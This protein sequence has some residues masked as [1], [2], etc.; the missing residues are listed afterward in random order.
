M[1]K[2]HI[3]LIARGVLI[4]ESQLLV[5]E[6]VK[7]KYLFLPGGHVEFGESVEIALIR[8]MMEESGRPVS[9]GRFMGIFE[10]SF[11]QA[12]EGKA[13]KRHHE[14]NLIYEMTTEDDVPIA[15][16]ESKIAFRWIPIDDLKSKGQ[17]RPAGILEVALGGA[18]QA[19]SMSE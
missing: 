13:A 16:I 10:A 8:E 1:S 2:S 12:R 6:N 4:R 3:E 14:V 7:S 19:A 9:V 5:C 17:L 15:S 11:Q 18:I